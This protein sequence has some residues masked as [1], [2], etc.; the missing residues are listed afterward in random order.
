MSELETSDHRN[1]RKLLGRA[2][3]ND[4]IL[5]EVHVAAHVGD[6]AHNALLKHN[7]LHLCGALEIDL[8]FLDKRNGLVLL[9]PVLII[10]ERGISG[11]LAVK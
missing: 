11:P 3:H 5:I 2:L 8:I 6:A 4:S 10:A 9:K 7:D 1:A